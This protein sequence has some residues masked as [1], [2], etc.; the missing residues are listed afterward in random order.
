M[1]LDLRQKP[2]LVQKPIMT[3]QL[4]QAI[5]LLQLSRLELE[6]TVRQELAENPALE[7][8]AEPKAEERLDDLSSLHEYLN[9]YDYGRNPSQTE[10]REYRDFETY[11]AGRETLTE[12]LLRQLLMTSPTAEEE[13]IGSLIAGSL[14]KDGYLTVSVVEIS[15]MSGCEPEKIERVLALMQ[16]FDPPGVCGRELKECLLLQIE[17]QDVENPVAKDIVS[18]HLAQLAKRDYKSIAKALGLKP[19]DVIAAAKLITSLEPRP[20]RQF[21]DELPR[22]IEPDIFVFKI[23]DEFVISLNNRGL[24]ELRISSFFR[25]ALKNGGAPGPKTVD[26]LREKLRSARWLIRSIQER[27]RTIYRV[28][29]SILR[30]QR[31]FFEK[32]IAHLKP[33]VLRDVAED[34]EMAESTVSRATANK[35]AHTPHGIFELK[36]FF[37]SHVNSQE[38]EPV[39]STVVQEKIRKIVSAED[40]QKPLS[41]D[42]IAKLLQGAGI[43]I[44]RRTVAKYRENI[45]I[46]ASSRRKQC[47][48]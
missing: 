38:G 24:P 12:H 42:R 25:Q 36:Y 34:I 14:N 29:E 32:G 4:Q 45:G 37:S 27:R 13:K 6:E 20:G 18:K 47:K 48:Y 9:S 3:L 26:F 39:S 28:M 40:P 23:R 15:E 43:D 21:N 7:E 44:A 5:K 41:D 33:M 2:V 19:A 30:S 10:V 31:D 46:L 22:Y 17:R 16:G 11:T 8:V 1:F 35:Y